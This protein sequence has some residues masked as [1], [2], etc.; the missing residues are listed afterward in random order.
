MKTMLTLLFIAASFFVTNTATAQAV[1]KDSVNALK[2]EK[3]I[4]KLAQR[5]NEAKLKLAAKQNEI[6]SRNSDIE[7]ANTAAQKAA[8]KNQE[9]AAKLADDPQN[10]NKAKEA[11]NAARNA[12]NKTADARKAKEKLND[13]LG[14]I[15]DLNKKIATDEKK[16]NEMR[17]VTVQ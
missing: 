7:R 16:I 4:L 3:E 13:L 1:S 17:G 11:K 14:D 6:S 10:K 5:I 9:A 8:E 15:D 12:D 2:N